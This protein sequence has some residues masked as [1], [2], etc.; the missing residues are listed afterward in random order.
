MTCT[1]HGHC[2]FLRG[3][4]GLEILSDQEVIEL[5]ILGLVRDQG[6]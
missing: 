2:F 3:Q 4:N 5:L 6:T 1:N